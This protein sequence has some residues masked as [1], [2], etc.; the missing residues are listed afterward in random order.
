[1]SLRSATRRDYEQVTGKK[2]SAFRTFKRLIGDAGFR[3]VWLYRRGYWARRHGLRLPA[4][5]IERLI[6]HLCHCG[7]STTAEIAPGFVIRH[8]GSVV[9]GGGVTIESGCEIRQGVTLGG[10]YG[11][12]LPDGRSQPIMREGVSVGA[13]AK[14]L[15]PIT[16]GARSI[17]GANAVVVSDVPPDSVAAGV[18]ARII[19]N[20]GQRIPITE[21]PG[22]LAE[23][24]GEILSRLDALEAS[25]RTSQ[26]P[27]QT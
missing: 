13:G 15:G 27:A 26:G 22:E 24:L 25:L 21:S 19:R 7:V 11:R 16:V 17:V 1:M 8:V 2:A 14:I 5:L 18:P 23:L 10:N 12:K 9:V 3:A 20:A 6:H 4:I